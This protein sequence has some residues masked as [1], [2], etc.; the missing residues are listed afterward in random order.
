MTYVPL[1]GVNLQT[2]AVKLNEKV[3]GDPIFTASVGWLSQWKERHSIRDLRVS[4]KMLSSD[5]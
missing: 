3:K 4:G 5:S 1:L 2:I